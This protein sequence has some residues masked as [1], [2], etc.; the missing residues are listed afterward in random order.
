[1]FRKFPIGNLADFTGEWDCKDDSGFEE[2]MKKIGNMRG[3]ADF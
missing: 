3:R 2:T 1:M